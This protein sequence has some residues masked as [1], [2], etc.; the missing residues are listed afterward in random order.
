MSD[1]IV[2]ATAQEATAEELAGRLVAVIDVLRATTVILTALE[3]GAGRVVTVAEVDEA[4]RLRAELPG[5]LLAGERG[6]FAP[7]GFDYG[8]SPVEIARADLAGRDVVLTTTNGTLAVQR[9]GAA[10]SIVAACLR[11]AGAVARSLASGEGPVALLCAGTEGAFT[12]E[13]FY[14]AGLIAA[15]LASRGYVLNDLAWSAAL[16]GGRPA[17]E[18]INE[19][20]CSHVRTLVRRGLAADLPYCLELDASTAVP[21]YEKSAGGMA[22]FIL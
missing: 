14:C 13:D 6:G 8:N 19:R 5:A 11:N 12:I 4:R 1:L 20:T 21:R 7:E 18:A 9:A 3:R 17:A 22:A 10:A 15:D 2:L 16:L